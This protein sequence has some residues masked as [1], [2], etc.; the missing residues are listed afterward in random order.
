MNKR[1][2]EGI[3][4]ALFKEY[5]SKML[6][7]ATR[8]V[9]ENDAEDIVQVAFLELWKRKDKIL[10]KEHAKA[11]LFRVVYTRSVNFVKHRSVTS[12]YVEAAKHLDMLRVTYYQPDNNE[13]IKRMEN[14]ALKK[15]IYEAI[16]ELPKR[17]REVFK[18]SYLYYMKNKEIA[19]IL[20]IAVKTVEAHMSK[21]IK[22]LRSRLGVFLI[23]SVLLMVV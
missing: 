2:I 17:C 8:L 1:G 19:E 21:A 6:F 4:K 5:Y 22:Y 10:I 18:M 20:G 9:G 7:Y 12:D 3:F 13:I 11:F 16:E 23:I 15:D 14:A